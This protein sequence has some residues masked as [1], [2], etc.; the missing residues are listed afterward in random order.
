MVQEPPMKI[1][2]AAALLVLPALA[3]QGYSQSTRE[4]ARRVRVEAMRD[5][6]AARANAMR[7]ARHVRAEAVRDAARMRQEAMRAGL[8]ARRAAREARRETYHERRWYF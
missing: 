7:A 4:E 5:A 8:A 3:Y 6:Q 2:L 1:L